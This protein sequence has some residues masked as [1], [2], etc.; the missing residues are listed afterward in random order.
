MRKYAVSSGLLLKTCQYI[1]PSANKQ[2][3][4]TGGKQQ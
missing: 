2:N 4:R 3:C 1:L